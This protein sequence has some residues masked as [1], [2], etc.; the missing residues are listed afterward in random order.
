LSSG[1]TTPPAPK[2]ILMSISF[3]NDN[4]VIV[5]ALE[6]IIP[7]ARHNQHI[8]VAQCVWWLASIIG[9]QQGVVVYIDTLK[10]HFAIKFQGFS[11]GEIPCD[12]MSLGPVIRKVSATPRDL[13]QNLCTEQIVDL[14]R[15]L[16]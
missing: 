12:R 5:Y 1:S 3:K 11:M 15:M 16:H 2:E 7:Y 10:K 4:E 9:S 8:I 6:K 13:A 14:I